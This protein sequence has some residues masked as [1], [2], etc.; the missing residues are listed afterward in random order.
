MTRTPVKSSAIKS[1]GHDAEKNILQVE[2]HTGHVYEYEGVT[3]EDHAALI[4][5]SSVGAHM[6]N[7]IMGKFPSRKYGK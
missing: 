2:F 6:N 3:E 1:I 7:F 5:A 4:S